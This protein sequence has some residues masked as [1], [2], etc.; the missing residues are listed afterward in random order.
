MPPS[1]LSIAHLRTGS[2]HARTPARVAPPTDTCPLYELCTPLPP[3]EIRSHRF[4][5]ARSA[6][7]ILTWDDMEVELGG[8][9][10]LACPQSGPCTDCHQHEPH[11]NTIVVGIGAAST[12]DGR[13]DGRASI[14][15]YFGASNAH[16]IAH[17]LISPRPTYQMAMLEACRYVLR[18]TQLCL[19]EWKRHKAEATTIT[20]C[21][22]NV[23]II[24]TD[25]E[26]IVRG[27]TEW[28]P[29]W[30][31]NGWRNH[32]D[33]PV[34]FASLWREIDSLITA[35][36]RSIRVVF[37]HVPRQINEVAHSMARVALQM[38]SHR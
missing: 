35:L 16:N 7:R 28:L 29:N 22:L 8:W 33:E 13:F 14:A 9:V 2:T 31:V 10:F 38:V 18:R 37:W 11:V 1:D 20:Q 21:C 12:H 15:A 34:S 30:K 27:Y 25:S 3:N 5:P 6:M 24:K 19:D 36:E 4:D 32:R 26:F 23:L 17:P